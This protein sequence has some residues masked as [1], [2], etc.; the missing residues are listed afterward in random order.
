MCLDLVRIHLTTDSY[1]VS[2]AADG[3]GH[4]TTECCPVSAAVDGASCCGR[5]AYL[6]IE[7][8]PLSVAVDELDIH[9]DH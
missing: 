9:L 4:L 6:T 8:C 5:A 1:H 3:T 7:C 2:V